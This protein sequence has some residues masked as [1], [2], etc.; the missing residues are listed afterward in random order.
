MDFETKTSRGKL[1]QN[2]LCGIADFGRDPELLKRAAA[3]LT[4]QTL[5]ELG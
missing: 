3:Y 2:C 5:G 4:K 1:C